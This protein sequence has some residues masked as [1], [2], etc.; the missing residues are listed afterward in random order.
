MDVEF[1]TAVTR[2]LVTLVLICTACYLAVMGTID[3]KDFLSL[4]TIVVLFWF[5][6]RQDE[7]S[8]QQVITQMKAIKEEVAKEETK[9]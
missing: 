5:K 3:P 9:K 4:A 2:P 8:S 7:K 6:E 1:W